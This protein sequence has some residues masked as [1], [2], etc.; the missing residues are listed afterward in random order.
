MTKSSLNVSE[1][2]FVATPFNTEQK[3]KG[4]NVK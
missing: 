4:R 3:T 2:H 1:M